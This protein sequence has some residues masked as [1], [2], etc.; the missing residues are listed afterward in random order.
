[1]V[2]MLLKEHNQGDPWTAPDPAL[3]LALQQVRW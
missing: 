1:M 3:A 2:R